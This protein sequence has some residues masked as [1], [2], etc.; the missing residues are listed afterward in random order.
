M[1]KAEVKKLGKKK[2]SK[3]DAKLPIVSKVSRGRKPSK[4]RTE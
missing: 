1:A 2:T 3:R 4:K